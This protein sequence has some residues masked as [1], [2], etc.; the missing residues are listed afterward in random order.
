MG[1]G[2]RLWDHHPI[3]WQNIWMVF[4]YILPQK[5]W[6]EAGF[7]CEIEIGS[8]YN[9]INF[10][11]VDRKWRRVLPFFKTHLLSGYRRIRRTETTFFYRCFGYFVQNDRTGTSAELWCRS[12]RERKSRNGRRVNPSKNRGHVGSVW[13]AMSKSTTK[14]AV[15]EATQFGQLLEKE[16]CR[17][18]VCLLEWRT[19]QLR[20]DSLHGEAESALTNSSILW[21]QL[22]AQ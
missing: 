18:S 20:A 4:L 3:G 21:L 12:A 22:E 5:I 8:A 14:I 17:L 7:G 9:Q 15:N 11:G 19:Q 10:L 1:E 2:S 13:V 16:V 6:G